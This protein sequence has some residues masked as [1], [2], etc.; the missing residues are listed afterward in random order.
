[1]FITP[2][3]IRRSSPHCPTMEARKPVARAW[4]AA[5]PLKEGF[6][7]YTPTPSWLPGLKL[8]VGTPAVLSSQAAQAT[9]A[10]Q[11]KR[12]WKEIERTCYAK[13]PDAPASMGADSWLRSAAHPPLARLGRAVA[14]TLGLPFGLFE[15]G[16]YYGG[17]LVGVAAGLVGMGIAP[18]MAAYM[19][20]QQ[21]QQLGRAP[22]VM[23]ATADFVPQANSPFS[24]LFKTGA[25]TMVSLV[26][27]RFG[28]HIRLDIFVDGHPPRVLRS[29]V[30]WGRGT[31]ASLAEMT[32]Q[33]KAEATPHAPDSLELEFRTWPYWE[34]D[35]DWRTVVTK[36][37]AHGSLLYQVMGKDPQTHQEVSLGELRLTS[38]FAASGFGDVHLQ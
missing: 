5:S 2:S 4:K 10:Q 34:P 25:K 35:E 6:P 19:T 12:I 33:G 8:P 16:K 32:S 38:R 20:A 7:N 17:P 31:A 1:M 24:G 29:G 22:R 11:Q 27:G 30:G 15:V 26:A 3:V 21:V 9:G 37:F 14:S 36:R 18:V 13:L 23:T 28:P